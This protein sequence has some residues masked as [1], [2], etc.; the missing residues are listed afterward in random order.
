MITVH[1]FN[2]DFGSDPSV[3]VRI[4][5]RRCVCAV[6]LQRGQPTLW[7]ERDTD[8]G[9][10]GDLRFWIVGTGHPVPEEADIFVGTVIWGVYVWHIYTNPGQKHLW[11][12]A[13]F[14]SS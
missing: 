5:G 12:R 6:G 10:N 8:V 2:F 1:K 4:P 13:T 11:E 9:D 7:V 14:I 3:A